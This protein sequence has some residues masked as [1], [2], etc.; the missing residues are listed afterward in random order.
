MS[1][2]PE[3][4]LETMVMTENRRQQD[5][6]PSPQDPADQPCL[7]TGGEKCEPIPKTTPPNLAVPEP[8]EVECNCPK[9]PGSR[10]TCIDD[11]IT[12]YTNDIAAADAAKTF[13]QDLDAVLTKAKAADQDY[14]RDKYHALVKAWVE[15]D[16]KIADLIRRLVCGIPCWKCLI[17]CY[18]C[19]LLDEM[20]IAEV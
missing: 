9:P 18:V 4:H 7:P 20:R 8:C 11:L 14:T 19:Q 6:P 5:C 12:K 15:N 10:P 1:C 2:S 13:K 3:V 16:D 17:E